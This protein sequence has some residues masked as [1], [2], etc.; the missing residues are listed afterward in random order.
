MNII[1][2]HEY[3]CLEIEINCTNHDYFQQNSK[4][5]LKGQLVNSLTVN[6]LAFPNHRERGL[7]GS[8]K[9]V[10]NLGNWVNHKAK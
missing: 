8:L 4:F 5:Y 9:G 2:Y 3:H 7:Q 10:T 1:E 6:A